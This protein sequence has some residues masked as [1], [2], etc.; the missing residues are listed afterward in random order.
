MYCVVDDVDDVDAANIS[1][2]TFCSWLEHPDPNLDASLAAKLC[3]EG[4]T[5]F[6]SGPIRVKV[7]W[8]DC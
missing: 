3:T 6:A 1:K 4:G 7:S 2:P 5:V 8:M